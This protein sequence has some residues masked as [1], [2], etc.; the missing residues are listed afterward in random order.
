MGAIRTLT[1]NTT[2]NPKFILS[3]KNVG[4]EKRADIERMANL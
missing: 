2:V 1:P 3:T 4:S